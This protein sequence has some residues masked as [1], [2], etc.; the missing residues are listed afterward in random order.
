MILRC[1]I[2]L[3]A[4]VTLAGAAHALPWRALAPAPAP[5]PTPVQAQATDVPD[6]VRLLVQ[7]ARR[8][9][10]RGDMATAEA[11]YDAIR[12]LGYIVRRPA[13]RTGG[14]HGGSRDE[15]GGGN[16]RG[17][18]GD[19]DRDDDDDGDDGDDDDDDDDDD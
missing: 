3:F 8:A 2:G 18:G 14:R 19:D 16:D 7:R 12:E 13:P 5:A 15:D 10:R 1:L 6:V 4:V 9:E 17:R 11:L